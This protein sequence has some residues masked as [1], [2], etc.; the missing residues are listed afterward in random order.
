[1][2]GDLRLTGAGVSVTVDVDGEAGLPDGGRGHA[3]RLTSRS[4][5]VYGI[6]RGLPRILRL[7]AEHGVDATF[8]VPGVTAQRHPDA[9]AAILAGGHE[10]GH[11]GHHHLRTDTLAARAERTELLDGLD[12]LH[13]AGAPRPR[14]YRSPGWELTPVTLAALGELG[15]EADSSLMGDDR[16]YALAAGG[17]TL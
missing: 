14:A 13:A 3:G 1:M 4:E 7:L 16:P 6:A 12:A 5:R 9:V 2:L 17:A 15:F 10:I 11:H 8:Y